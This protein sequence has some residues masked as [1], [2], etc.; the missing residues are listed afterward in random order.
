MSCFSPSL[1]WGEQRA[2][3]NALEYRTEGKKEKVKNKGK[4]EKNKGQKRALEEK[5]HQRQWISSSYQA[6]DLYLPPPLQSWSWS[7]APTLALWVLCT[8]QEWSPGLCSPQTGSASFPTPACPALLL[9][10]DRDWFFPFHKEK[11]LHPVP[12]GRTWP[13]GS[14]HPWAVIQGWPQLCLPARPCCHLTSGGQVLVGE[15][16][17]FFPTVLEEGGN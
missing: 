12:S 15:D 10:M 2:S 11:S 17:M 3:D 7:S 13:K 6:G 4:K 14:A 8:P 1:C 16:I 9:D 5:C